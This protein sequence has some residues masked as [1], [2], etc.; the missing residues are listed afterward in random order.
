MTLNTKHMT[1]GGGGVLQL[2]RDF[3]GKSK[4]VLKT[5]SK[6]KFWP[7]EGFRIA[8]IMQPPKDSEPKIFS[9]VWLIICIKTAP[10]FIGSHC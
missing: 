8:L 6:Y 3:Q 1:F 10:L 7:W 2:R 5:H 9:K 4:K